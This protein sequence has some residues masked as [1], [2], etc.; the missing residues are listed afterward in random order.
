M[1]ALCYGLSRFI[2][3]N[4]HKIFYKEKLWDVDEP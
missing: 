2:F 4:E 3:Y 1:G